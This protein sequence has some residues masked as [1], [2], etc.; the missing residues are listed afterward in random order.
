MNIARLALGL[1]MSMTTSG[2]AMAT[3][4][5]TYHFQLRENGVVVQQGNL[6]LDAGGPEQGL[7][8]PR[9]LL[10]P[11]TGEAASNKAARVT[12]P[13]MTRLRQGPGNGVKV[14]VQYPVFGA[15]RTV[16]SR[17]MAMQ[18]PTLETVDLYQSVQVEK[19]QVLHFRLGPQA[20]FPMVDM[21]LTRVGPA[22]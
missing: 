16:T 3:V 11:W 14:H 1:M 18:V 2:M 21:S 12:A 15:P 7:E 6:V 5:N 8:T 20:G 17:M 10:Y 13:L 9:T 22:P 19:G 4:S